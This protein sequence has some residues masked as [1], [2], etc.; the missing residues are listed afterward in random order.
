MGSASKSSKLNSGW[1]NVMTDNIRDSWSWNTSAAQKEKTFAFQR[2]DA[3]PELK[4]QLQER[5]QKR[6][7]LFNELLLGSK[8]IKTD[9]YGQLHW[10]GYADDHAALV[11]P[12]NE[13]RIAEDDKLTRLEQ[14]LVR[15]FTSKNLH[16]LNKHHFKELDQLKGITEGNCATVLRDDLLSLSFQLKAQLLQLSSF[17]DRMGIDATLE[18]RERDLLYE[19]SFVNPF[20]MLLGVLPGL[21]VEQKGIELE[22]ID[23]AFRRIQRDLYTNFEESADGIRRD[24]GLL[25]KHHVVGTYLVDFVVLFQHFCGKWL[26]ESHMDKGLGLLLPSLLDK[27]KDGGSLKS[28]LEKIEAQDG[29]FDTLA[30][31]ARLQNYDLAQFT[32]GVADKW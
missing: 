14:Q 9:E 22:N 28:I 5:G 29:G 20:A 13:C 15:K 31:A 27:V 1:R 23:P 18:G 32:Y 25:L 30:G 17:S 11:S 7:R 4:A 8:P 21:T 26:G 24:V 6:A 12:F 2:L 19:L 16:G 10:D 3:D